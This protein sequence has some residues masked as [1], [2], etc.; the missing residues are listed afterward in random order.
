MTTRPKTR[1]GDWPPATAPLIGCCAA[2]G[3]RCARGRSPGPSPGP[4]SGPAPTP[5]HR[6][7]AAR[8]TAPLPARPSRGAAA[9]RSGDSPLSQQSRA[10]RFFRH[11]PRGRCEAWGCGPS[12]EAP[13]VR[14]ARG[15][16]GA[17]PRRLTQGRAAVSSP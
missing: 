17:R 13:G 14:E 11:R 8:D 15:S 12:A 16:A 4:G 7:G 5:C 3:L 6:T 9:P 10:R 1:R 2:R